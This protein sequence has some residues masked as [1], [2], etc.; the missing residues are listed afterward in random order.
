MA[1]FCL[2]PRKRYPSGWWQIFPT[3]CQTKWCLTGTWQMHLPWAIYHLHMSHHIYQVLRLEN[4]DS[5]ISHLPYGTPPSTCVFINKTT[6]LEFPLN[7]M[8]R[9]YSIYFRSTAFTG[10]ARSSADWTYNFHYKCYDFT[11]WWGDIA[12]VT[13][14]L[15]WPHEWIA[16]LREEMLRRL[17]HKI[18]IGAVYNARPC[19][20]NKIGNFQPQGGNSI[21]KIWLE[22]RLKIPFWFCDI[23]K[24]SIF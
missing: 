15:G 7:K 4:F 16:P 11:W 22:K 23:S 14:G 13:L 20:H 18:D 8:A 17:P 12:W 2:L 9:W 10:L 6:L 3:F 5:A 19:D 24:L 1:D 21:A